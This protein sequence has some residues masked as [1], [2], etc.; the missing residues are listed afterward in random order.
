METWTEFVEGRG[1]LGPV[2]DRVLESH[3]VGSDVSDTSTQRPK[4][5]LMDYRGDL[6]ASLVIKRVDTGVVDRVWDCV[7]PGSYFTVP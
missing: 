1:A 2:Q 5:T 3:D 7:S 6:H 4:N